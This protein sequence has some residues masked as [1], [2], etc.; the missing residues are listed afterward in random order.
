MGLFQ[1]PWC[2]EYPAWL[3]PGA[4][5]A[6]GGPHPA[7]IRRVRWADDEPLDIF[8]AEKVARAFAANC[9]Q[10]EKSMAKL[11]VADFTPLK[12]E[13]E[14]PRVQDEQEC[15]EQWEAQ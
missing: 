14:Q 10:L 13:E 11:S 12:Q 9:A 1:R 2:E 15:I 3:S 4:T 6:E 7:K 5:E 8:A